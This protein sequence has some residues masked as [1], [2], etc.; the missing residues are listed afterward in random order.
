MQQ[1]T[2]TPYA[3]RAINAA[4]ASNAI[5]LTAPLQGTNISGTIPITNLP[6]NTAFL[7]SNQTFTVSN[8]FSGVVTAN[9][10]AN[11]LS[12][13]FSGNGAGLLNVP[14][15]SLTGTLP[16]ARLSSNV[17]LQSN[18]NLVFAGNVTAVNLP[19]PATD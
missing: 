8:T 4:N 16:D 18:P 3:I 11:A 17:A 15:T 10:S 5:V 9:N 7:N 13:A 6:P 1:I 2:S 12:G 19:A 14:A